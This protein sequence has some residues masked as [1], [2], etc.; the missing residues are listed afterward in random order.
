VDFSLSKTY[1]S[2]SV[3]LI[4]GGGYVVAW[5]V[6]QGNPSLDVCFQRYDASGARAGAIT[7]IDGAQTINGVSVK[8]RADGGFTVAWIQ[9]ADPTDLSVLHW[10]DYDAAGNAQ[11]AIQV[12]APPVALLG[13]RLAG[14]GFVRLLLRRDNQVPTDSFQLFAADGTPIGS[15]QPLAGSADATGSITALAGGGF[16]VAWLQSDG[17]TSSVAMTG[18]FSADGTPLGQ[19]VAVAPNTLGPVGCGRNGVAATCPPFQNVAGITATPDGGYIVEWVDGTGVGTV[20]H[21][22]VREFRADGSP[23]SAVIG[24]MG[25]GVSGSIA[26]INA[27]TFVM[28]TGIAGATGVSVLRVDAPPLH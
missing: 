19:P 28:G 21:T 11:G 26:A 16:A 5:S 20:G 4:G 23:A 13:E 12:G 25:S 10:Q 7:C 6:S 22:F 18:A 3:A 9:T 17:G 2:P 14:G 1:S 8:S 27:D 24:D 15:P